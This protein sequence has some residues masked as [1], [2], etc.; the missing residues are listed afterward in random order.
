[1]SPS[2][3]ASAE[4]G[5]VSGRYPE[6]DGAAESLGPGCDGLGKEGGVSIEVAGLGEGAWLGRGEEL[7]DPRLRDRV[8]GQVEVP[9][10]GHE[11]SPPRSRVLGHR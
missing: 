9:A 2:V 6:L 11:K 10:G 3:L 1:M 8:N 4:L 5:E 7:G